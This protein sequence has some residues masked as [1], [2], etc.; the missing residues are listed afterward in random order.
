MASIELAAD[1]VVVTLDPD[2]LDLLREEIR[3]A[4]AESGG[5]G[6]GLD[7]DVLDVLREEIR[8]AGGVSDQVVDALR[9]ELKALR[10]R[11]AVK[12][13]EKVLD[14]AQLAQIADAVAERLGKG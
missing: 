11:L 9:E 1:D 5:D 8:A 10:R 4:A 2:T 14:E 6:A 7:P 3:S 13:A 12:A